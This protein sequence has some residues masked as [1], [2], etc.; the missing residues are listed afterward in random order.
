MNG[1]SLIRTWVA[2]A[3][4][5]AVLYF[6]FF[7][8]LDAFGV[9]GP[10]EPRYASI[11]RAMAETGDWVTP[12]LDGK[13]WFEKPVFYYWSAAAAFRLFG[14]SESSARLP[15]AVSATLAALAL[16][17]LAWRTYGAGTAWAV[18]LIF[19]TCAGVFAFAR[20]GT[21]DMPFSAALALAMVAAFH[22]VCD[23]EK[24]PQR[25]RQ[26]LFGALLGM[27]ALAKGP[28]A[29]VLAG[30]SVG[31]WALATGR[32]KQAWRLA[33]PLAVIAFCAVTLPWYVLC[34][35]RNPEFLSVFLLSHNVDRFLTPV[36][37]HEQPLW[38]YGP[39]LLLGLLPWSALLVGVA[40]DAA[41]AG[42]E[43]RWKGSHG[44][45]FACW[46]IFPIVFFSLSKSKLPGY[47]LPVFAPLALLMARSVT[48]AIEQKDGFAQ[49][50]MEWTGVTLLMLT[51]SAGYWLSKFPAQLEA[52]TRLEIAA[53][54]VAV[55]IAGLF[56]SGLA[57]ARKFWPALILAAVLMAGLIELVNQRF[58]PALDKQISP[59]AAARVIQAQGN[60]AAG[61]TVYRLH[62]AWHYG[63]NFYMHREVPAWQPGS[64]AR[65]PELVVTSAAG[66]KEL[67]AAGVRFRVIERVSRQAVVVGVE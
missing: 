67:E 54:I 17:G 24:S 4:A 35:M 66:A 26:F 49:W 9:I 15:S 6:C 40:R 38:F 60:V 51:G 14:V 7:S 19:P 53:G 39:I 37:Q 28:A 44:F 65:G 52:M 42:R 36:F 18:L 11:A 13:P 64:A 23:D 61:V 25:L 47:V 8:R 3:L 56:V 5:A 46:A 41:T 29:I 27:A 21:T 45:F 2:A 50:L 57:W 55:L 10:D 32:W 43:K 48:R 31:L 33:H 58:V 59:R 16:A 12:R 63:L 1:L 20:A 30:G 62:R 22:T 34:A